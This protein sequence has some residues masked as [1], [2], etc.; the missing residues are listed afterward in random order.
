VTDSV[1]AGVGRALVHVDLAPSAG[2]SAGADA[3]VGVDP[4]HAL[5]VIHAGRVAAIVDVDL[6]I[7]AGE[8]GF[9]AAGVAVGLVR[10][11]AA[12][13][14]GLGGAFV[15]IRL[16][17]DSGVSGV[18][19]AA[20]PVDLVQALGVVAAGIRVALVDV[21]LA[22]LAGVTR[23]A[24][25][26]VVPGL[27]GASAAVEAGPGG[28]VVAVRTSASQT[29]VFV[30]R[31]I[32]FLVLVPD[33]VG[34]LG[35]SAEAGEIRGV[36]VDGT[37]SLTE[38]V[39]A[40]DLPS[41]VVAAKRL[42]QGSVAELF[43]NDLSH[44]IIELIVANCSPG[45]FVVNL[46]S[47][48]EWGFSADQSDWQSG[49]GA[50]QAGSWLDDNRSSCGRSRRHC[51]TIRIGH[52]LFPGRLDG[53]DRGFALLFSEDLCGGVGDVQV[54]DVDLGESWIRRPS[55]ESA[56]NHH[57]ILIF[58]VISHWMGNLDQ[59]RALVAVDKLSALP[60]SETDERVEGEGQIV[61]LVGGERGQFDG[62]GAAFVGESPD[63]HSVEG[64][65]AEVLALHESVVAIGLWENGFDVV[66]DTVLIWSDGSDIFPGR[67]ALEFQES[68]AAA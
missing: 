51:T 1:Q 53:P 30:V 21:D 54:D 59:R 18:A 8:S 66:T 35:L 23:L 60:E 11:A 22:I 47:A 64:S 17:V 25:A 57:L 2:E 6:A 26:G 58:G 33:A 49:G 13:E 34:Q 28:A 29:R 24:G 38:E 20:V 44:D 12:V 32:V 3:R 63:Q 7:L 48:F 41:I 14:T 50:G 19:D 31:A 37:G 67:I 36:D 42:L 5:G 55:L 15:Q 16:A 4:V 65:Q 40:S 43:A 39:D 9:A 61:H 46:D 52:Q 62:P 45:S 10:A 27:V 56:A 68:T